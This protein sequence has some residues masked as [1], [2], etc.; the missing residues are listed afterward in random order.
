MHPLPKIEDAF[1]LKYKAFKLEVGLF[2][3]MF[4]SEKK[5]YDWWRLEY[6]TTGKRLKA[7]EKL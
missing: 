4:L 5:T 6:L 7:G 2:T 3:W 1:I